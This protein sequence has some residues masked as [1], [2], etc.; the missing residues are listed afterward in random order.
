MSLYDSVKQSE[1][2]SLECVTEWNRGEG[3][4]EELFETIRLQRDMATSQLKAA[5]HTEV[6]LAEKERECVRLAAKG[7]KYELR[8]EE[9]QE[10][11]NDLRAGM[12]DIRAALAAYVFPDT[13]RGIDKQ[14]AYLIEKATPVTVV[15][16]PTSPKGISA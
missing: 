11:V 5:K 1:G 6:A 8:A 3:S 16:F 9:L 12:D 15:E 13:V 10:E 7:A 4:L 2:D 14:I